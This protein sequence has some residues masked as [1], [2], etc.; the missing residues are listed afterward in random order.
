[1][2]LSLSIQHRATSCSK[3][4]FWQWRFFL[5]HILFPEIYMKWRACFKTAASPFSGGNY[6]HKKLPCSSNQVVEGNEVFKCCWRLYNIRQK[7]L[8][9]FSKQRRDLYYKLSKSNEKKWSLL[10]L[11]NSSNNKKRKL[12]C[13]QKRQQWFDDI[14]RSS[15]RLPALFIQQVALGCLFSW[16]SQAE[17]KLYIAV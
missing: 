13:L 14:Q 17:M 10:E 3:T 12:L 9:S 15:E 4:I 11:P 2:R 7:N 16:H 6:I 1:M 5:W 8:T